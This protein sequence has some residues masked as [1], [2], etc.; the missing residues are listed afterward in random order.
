MN[1][2][3]KEYR[4]AKK[5]VEKRERE[6]ALKE[7]AEEREEMISRLSEE[8]KY[9]VRQYDWF[10]H[11]WFDIK[12]DILKKEAIKIWDEYTKNG[13]RNTRYEDGDYYA[14]FPANTRMI[15]S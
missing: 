6:I 1:K 10:D 8:E 7:R 3:E 5:I 13:T 4:K 11:L 9:V 14:I 12:S 2:E 15:R